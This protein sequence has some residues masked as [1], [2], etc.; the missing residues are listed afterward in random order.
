MIQNWQPW[1]KAGVKT[2]EG[3]EI[4][5]LNAWKHGAYSAEVKRLRKVLAGNNQNH[6]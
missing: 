2:P 1:R 3:K 4:S 6:S 5:R